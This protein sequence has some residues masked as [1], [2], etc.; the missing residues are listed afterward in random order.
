LNLPWRSPWISKTIYLDGAGPNPATIQRFVYDRDHIWLCFDGNNNVTHRYLYGPAIDMVLVEE[1]SASDVR[2][3][4]A[5]NQGTIRDITNN[6]GAIQNHI[7]YNSFGR[8]IS[9]T[10]ANVYTRFNYTGR[11]FDGETGLYYY[12]SRYYD[13]VVGRFLSE[14]AIG[15]SF[16]H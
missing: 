9:Q 14:D 10:N 3:S 16:C 7:T 1:R 4:L 15:F 2:W 13:C 5:D 6:A 8:I 12:R 11:E